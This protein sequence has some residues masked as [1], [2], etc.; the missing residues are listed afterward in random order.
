MSS[1]FVYF[2]VNQVFLYKFIGVVLIIEWFQK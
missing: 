1:V 2:N